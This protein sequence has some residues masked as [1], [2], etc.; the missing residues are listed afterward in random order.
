M[1]LA[2]FEPLGPAEQRL[3]DWL[4]AG[5]RGPCDISEALPPENTS[6]V[7][8]RA[9]LIRYLALG[10]CDACRPPETGL[11][12][13][14]AWIDGNDERGKSTKG[15]DFQGA[16]LPGELTLYSCRIPDLILLNSA[17]M[18]NLYLNG[19]KLDAGM[20]AD[21]LKVKENVGLYGIESDTSINLRG[22][23]IPGTLYLL[24][25][26]KIKGTLSLMAAEIGAIEDDKASWPGRIN[27]NRCRY[28]AFVGNAAPTDAK[29]RLDWLSRIPTQPGE[30]LPDA[31]EHCAKVLREMGHSKDARLILIKKDQLQLETIFL[32]NSKRFGSWEKQYYFFRSSVD[33]IWRFSTGYG[34]EPLRALRP[35]G[36]FWAIGTLIFFITASNGQIKPNLPQMQIHPAWVDCGATGA[37]WR[38]DKETQVD[39]FLAQPE[40]RSYPRFNALIYSAD[41][42][43]PVVSLE[44]Q[45]YWIPDD[46]QPFGKYA[47]W[48]LWF[49]IIAGWALTLLAVAGFSG[50]IKT[51]SK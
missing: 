32:K 44:M 19:S 33:A 22:A 18:T 47:R 35:L 9:T 12:V 38:G 28:G 10:G 30:F 6:E 3:V 8:L 1:K 46:T 51:D 5:R 34:R 39:C 24:G 49:H 41:T 17:Q 42:L 2:N 23:K 50:L 4:K 15:L 21:G 45:S 7:R 11:R 27:L 16:S 20:I 40:G 14:G 37:R 26:A 48:Y 36:L 29:S 13:R 25:N 43:L 31:Y